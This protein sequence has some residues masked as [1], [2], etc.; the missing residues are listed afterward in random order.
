MA[1][2]LNSNEICNLL[3]I[4]VGLTEPQSDTNMDDEVEYNLK[5]LIDIGDWVL[6]GI[7]FA[8]RHRHSLCDSSRAIG[9]RS[10]ATMLEWKNWLT[11]KE[12]ELSSGIEAEGE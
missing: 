3:D 6:D 8:A 4:L 7:Y 10:Y 12:E 11:E 1:K 2:K 9:E 5:T